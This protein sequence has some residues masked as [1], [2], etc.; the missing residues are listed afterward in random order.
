[1]AEKNTTLRAKIGE[2]VYDLLPKTNIYNVWVDASTTLA[3]KLSEI[4]NALNNNEDGAGEMVVHITRNDSAPWYSADKTFA[5]IAEAIE[6]GKN[7]T[8]VANFG[9]YMYNSLSVYVPDELINFCGVNCELDEGNNPTF[10]IQS[11]TIT[12]E[13]VELN[14]EPLAIG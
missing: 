5:E 6:A 12:P 10:G 13:S 2:V 11:I 9:A 3:S 8:A 4:T 1:M 7:V 14:S